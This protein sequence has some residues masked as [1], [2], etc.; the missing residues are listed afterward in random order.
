MYNTMYYT[1]QIY[2]IY[3]SM[4]SFLYFRNHFVEAISKHIFIFLS[5]IIKIPVLFL[6]QLSLFL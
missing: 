5:I 3:L 6:L 4:P 1:Y 2:N